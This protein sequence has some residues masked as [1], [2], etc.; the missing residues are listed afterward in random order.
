MPKKTTIRDVAE[1]SGVAISTVS[2]FFNGQYV[3]AELR[4]RLRRVAKRLRY[5][6]SS[7]ARNLGLGRC[8]SIG[9][10][11]QSTEDAWF[12]MMLAGVQEGLYEADVTLRLT[13]LEAHRRRGRLRVKQ[14][15]RQR[16][17]DGIVFAKPDAT[18]RPLIA[19]ALAASL[20]VV[21]VAPEAQLDRV[22]V[23]GLDDAAAGEVLAAHLISL[24]HREVAF[25][26]GEAE[27]FTF[28]R[29]LL[30]VRRGLAQ[31]GARLTDDRVFT[32]GAATADAGAEFGH[33]FLGRHSSVTALVIADELLAVGFL[34]AARERD[35]S[36][37]KA[38]SVVSFGGLP[39]GRL[40]VPALTT[41][42]QPAHAMG[43]TAVR[44]L[45]ESI[46]LPASARDTAFAMKLVVGD[47]AG[48]PSLAQQMSGSSGPNVVCITPTRTK[49]QA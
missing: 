19:A 43:R 41:M 28:V 9:I 31:V 21:A 40:S 7:V 36:I 6:P 46:R 45:I 37:P 11:V 13:S 14:W 38:L 20:P 23:V 44:Q 33:Q 3:S 39:A 12:G 24:G 1:Q 32:C 17:V 34:R 30:G 25:A 35:I 15:I 47:S 5:T 27:S 48:R 2:R 42:A 10:V 49:A 22:C 18:A 8:G 29:R 4:G 16:Q 26:G